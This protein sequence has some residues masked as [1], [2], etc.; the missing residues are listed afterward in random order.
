MTIED[1]VLTV[2]SIKQFTYLDQNANF[3]HC[4]MIDDVKTRAFSKNGIFNKTK[5]EIRQGK[6][7]IM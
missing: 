2:S 6:R 5:D 3:S 7:R 4:K 1:G